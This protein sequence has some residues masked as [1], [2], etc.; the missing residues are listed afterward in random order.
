[1]DGLQQQDRKNGKG[2]AIHV[3][4]E[5]RNNPTDNFHVPETDSGTIVVTP[6]SPPPAAPNRR[7]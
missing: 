6:A 5:D 4:L 2:D 7:P 1:M 3:D